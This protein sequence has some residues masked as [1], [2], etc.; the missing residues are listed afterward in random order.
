MRTSKLA[1]EQIEQVF[2]IADTGVTVIGVNVPGKSSK[3]K[4]INTFVLEGIA[5]LLASGEPVFEDKA[6]RALCESV[7]CYNSANHAVYMQEKGNLFTGSKD[8]GWRLTAPGLARGAELV[9]EMTKG[10]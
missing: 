7:G 9:K 8:K 10:A 2:E 5:R 4:T 3:E 6:A 1:K